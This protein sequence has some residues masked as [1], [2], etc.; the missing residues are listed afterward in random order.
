MY[1]VIRVNSYEDFEKIEGFDKTK[2][3]IEPLAPDIER[4]KYKVSYTNYNLKK[5][6]Y[7]IIT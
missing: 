5:H 2:V 7:F 4:V 1:N 6:Y 3:K